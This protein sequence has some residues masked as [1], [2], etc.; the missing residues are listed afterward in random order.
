MNHAV[1]VQESSFLQVADMEDERSGYE[2]DGKVGED[3]GKDEFVDASEELNADNRDSAVTVES[4]A[5]LDERSS[6]LKNNP[7]QMEN[8]EPDHDLMDEIRRVQVL[9]AKTVSEKESA[10]REYEV[11]FPVKGLQI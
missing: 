8:G 10:A 2:D 9:L 4:D 3:A 7:S 5:A 1:S 11:S 6:P